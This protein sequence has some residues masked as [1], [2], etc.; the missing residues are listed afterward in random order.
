MVDHGVR[1]AGAFGSSV[2]GYGHAGQR[3][4]RFQRVS[5]SYKFQVRRYAGR[6]QL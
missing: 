4:A 3:E 6:K 1:R 2:A 5:L